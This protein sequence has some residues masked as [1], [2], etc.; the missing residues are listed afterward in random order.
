[1]RQRFKIGGYDL[2]EDSRL[3][4]CLGGCKT[5][6]KIAQ[7]TC[8]LSRSALHQLEHTLV[9]TRTR[10]AVVA[11]RR[12]SRGNIRLKPAPLQRPQISRVNPVCLHQLLHLTILG[13]QGHCRHSAVRQH[14]LK[15]LRQSKPRAF[16]FCRRIKTA[17]LGLLYKSLNGSL[18]RP[19]NKGRSL[20]PDHFKGAHGLM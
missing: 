6:S 9:Q 3:P 2:P 1:M 19:Q 11:L 13:K 12:N 4:A 17:V 20:Q 15:I 7:I 18:H 5:K 16:N 8:W 14:A 10:A